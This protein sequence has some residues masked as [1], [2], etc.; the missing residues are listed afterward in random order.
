MPR[1][2]FFVY[3]MA[4]ATRGALYVGVTNSLKR[5]VAQHLAGSPGSFTHRYN[6]NRLVW[7]ESH[8]TPIEAIRR[9]KQLK[10]GPRRRKLALITAAN[11]RWLDLPDHI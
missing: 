5:R 6:V 8:T 1:R 2:L 3:I 11:P 10:A 9:E 4:S 7:Y